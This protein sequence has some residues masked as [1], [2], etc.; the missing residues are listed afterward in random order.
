[1]AKQFG[2]LVN[3]SE[4]GR[5]QTALYYDASGKQLTCDATRSGIDLGRRNIESGPFE[6]KED[7]PLVLRV[8]VDKSIVEVFANDRQAVARR[9]YPKLAGTGVRLFAKGGDV[10]I[11]SVKA[12][13]LMPSNPY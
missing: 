9:I 6:L 8:F 4:D 5:E 2:I 12:W 10:N 3:C 7:E 1:E 13:E 11:L